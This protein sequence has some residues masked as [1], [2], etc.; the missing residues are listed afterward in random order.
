MDRRHIGLL[1]LAAESLGS[2]GR[3]WGV[4]G[5]FMMQD[6]V[7]VI[8]HGIIWDNNMENPCFVGN[9]WDTLW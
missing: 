2:L 1:G 5:E 7:I 3:S 8:V 4:H 6:I 9:F